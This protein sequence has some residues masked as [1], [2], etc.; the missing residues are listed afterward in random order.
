MSDPEPPRRF[1]RALDLLALLGAALVATAAT[2]HFFGGPA[3]P[4]PVDPLLGMTLEVR[5][6]ADLP[7][8][9]TFAPAGSPVRIEGILRATVERA[10]PPDAGKPAWRVL[11]MKVLDRG[12]QDPYV[13]TEFR[14]GILRGQT[15]V[16]QDGT[17]MV[18]A[19]ILALEPAK[20]P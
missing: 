5:Y 3:A 14:N 18:N 1:P 11:R 16:V 2:F 13:L 6:D 7:W 4:L 8:K 9:T 12:G 10:D 17:S 15:V 20:K 19:E